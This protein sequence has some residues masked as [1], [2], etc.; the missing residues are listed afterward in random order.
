M[1]ISKNNSLDIKKSLGTLSA[2]LI[3]LSIKI[4]LFIFFS[5]IQAAK[6]IG[7][8]IKKSTDPKSKAGETIIVATP[9]FVKDVKEINGISIQSDDYLAKVLK[10]SNG[11]VR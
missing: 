3:C 11:Y 6:D 5:S 7:D 1:M 8:Y 9:E 10:Q 2:S 4:E